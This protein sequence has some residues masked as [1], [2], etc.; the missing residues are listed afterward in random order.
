MKF[1]FEGIMCIVSDVGPHDLKIVVPRLAKDGKD[2]RMNL[3]DPEP[4]DGIHWV[5]IYVRK[6]DALGAMI[7]K[8]IHIKCNTREEV[9]S[10]VDALQI[11]NAELKKQQ[12]LEK[13]QP[14]RKAHRLMV[15]SQTTNKE[16][17]SEIS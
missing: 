5:S 1:K 11:K 13:K 2:F 7:V 15:E 16:I 12:I 8:P 14:W 6:K 9:I 4:E 10:L 17:T 3:S